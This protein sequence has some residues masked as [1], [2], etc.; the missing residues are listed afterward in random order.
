MKKSLFDQKQVLLWVQFLLIFFLF[1]A[2]TAIASSPE[3]GASGAKHWL[4]TDW[5]RVMNF[6][7]LIAA[8]FFLLR[9]PVSQALNGRIEGIKTE[10]EELEE[11][12]KEAEKK[13][14]Q[15]NEQIATLEQE[16]EKI[17]AE[18]KRQGEAARERILDATKKAA[19]KM[20]DQAKKTIENE[21][22]NAKL[23]LQEDILEKALTKAEALVKD[24][25][26]SEDQDRLVDE[27]LDKVVA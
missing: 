5:Y 21:F 13:L 1:L 10:L 25:I 3:H 24:K 14:V 16:A 23:R 6:T 12:K 26:T 4:N 7:V 2:G 11:K 19:A 8:L 15:Y 22:K 17:I 9:K 27:Y 20:E 18:Y